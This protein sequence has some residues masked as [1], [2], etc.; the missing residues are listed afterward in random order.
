M[1]GHSSRPSLELKILL[2]SRPD[3]D[4]STQLK[5]FP[6]FDLRAHEEDLEIFVNKMVS[7]LPRQFDRLQDKAA[8][9]LLAGAGRSFLWVSIIMKE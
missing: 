2:T 4:I 3:P 1:N 8:E 9:L 7:D 6:C 5:R